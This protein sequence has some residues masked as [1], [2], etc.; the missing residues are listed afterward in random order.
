MFKN[1][2]R[3]NKYLAIIISLIVVIIAILIYFLK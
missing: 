3:K 2:E 1:N